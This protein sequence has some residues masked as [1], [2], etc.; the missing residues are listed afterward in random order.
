M[1]EK[2]TLSNSL[3]YLIQK[4]S[5]SKISQHYLIL[6]PDN[7]IVRKENYRSI[8]IMDVKVKILNKTLANQ[9]QHYIKWIIHSDQVEFIPGIQGWS[10][11]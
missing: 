8:F 7:N 1:D 2:G 6:K 5:A 4:L 3:Y 11:V 9:I 10:N